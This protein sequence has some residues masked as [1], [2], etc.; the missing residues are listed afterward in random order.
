M[1]D[2]LI[3]GGG[4]IGMLTAR[5]LTLAGASVTLVEKGDTAREST[6]AGGGILSPLYPWR[7]PDAVT[8]LAR[9]SQARYP[10]LM[11]QLHEA[12]EIDPEYRQSGLL[13]FTT[14]ELEQGLDWTRQWDMQAEVLD[15]PGLRALEPGLRPGLSEALWLPQVGQ[16]RNPRLARALRADIEQR[17][18]EIRTRTPVNGIVIDGGRATSVI[19]PDGP[20][21]ADLFVLCAGAWTSELLGETATAAIEPVRGQMILFHAEPEFIRHINLTADGYAIPRRDGRILY[22]STLEHAGFD[23]RTTGEAREQLYAAATSLFPDLRRFPIEHHWAGLRPGS[24]AGIPYI[25]KHPQADNLLVNAGH[26]RNGVVLGLGSA[27]LAAN[28]ALGQEPIL[29]PSPYGFS[30]KRG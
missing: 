22:G 29:D 21:S 24:P 9:Y 2:V 20:V 15:E 13:L 26:Y 7:Y 8:R 4:I 14:T 10:E 18:V 12:T 6:W 23:K 1:S 30:A 28:L 16:V 3:I 19:T 27:R 5:E 25:G 11:R 17:G